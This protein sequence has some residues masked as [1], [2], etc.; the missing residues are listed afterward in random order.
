VEEGFRGFPSLPDFTGRVALSSFDS[1]SSADSQVASNWAQVVKGAKVKRSHEAVIK[2]ENKFLGLSEDKK[3]LQ[4]MKN[5]LQLGSEAVKE[6]L[7]VAEKLDEGLLESARMKLNVTHV[8]EEALAPFMTIKNLEQD[9]EWRCYFEICLHGEASP[10]T[11]TSGN[12]RIRTVLGNPTELPQGFFTQPF[13]SAIFSVKNAVEAKLSARLARPSGQM[14][15]RQIP[16]ALITE[17]IREAAE[18][19]ESSRKKA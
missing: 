19:Q 10:R 11:Q 16:T 18:S 2:T 4:V 7:S 12:I 8:S 15:E 1:T 6:F 17:G 13:C 3:K 14:Q 5:L 9:E